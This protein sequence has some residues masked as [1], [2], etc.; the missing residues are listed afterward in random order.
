MPR[1]RRERGEGAVYYSKTRRRWIGQLDA[2]TDANGARVRPLVVG[3]TRDEART[4]LAELREARDKGIDIRSRHV[5]FDEVADLWLSRDV[6]GHVSEETLSNYTSLLHGRISR[7]IGGTPVTQLRATDVEKM[8]LE[9][10]E[11]G[12]SARYMRLARNL[13]ER[14]LDYAVRRDVVDRNVAAKVRAPAGPTAERYGLTVKQARR[15][16][17]V[18]AEDRLGNLVT[19]SL[20]LG[21]RPGEAA[22][23]TW[24]QVKLKGKR[25]TITVAASLRRTPMGALVLVPPKTRTSRRTL[26]V[27]P[28]VVAALKAQRAQQKADRAAA[29]RGWQ[30]SLNLVFTTEVG[31]PLDPSNVRRTYARLAQAAGLE[32][33]HPHMLRHAAASLLSAA[34]VPIEDISDTLGHRSVA[35]TAEVYRHP[36][37]PVRSG[38]MAAMDLL[39]PSGQP[40]PER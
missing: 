28:P 40:K 24:D 9:L 30:N 38:H 26:E 5:T 27:P 11:L 33:L 19:I 18:A 16:L 23:L 2:G 39:V 4:R 15:L 10:Q 20:L 1:Q 22:G 7:A 21:L 25:P 36:I 6:A 3:R 31:T 13:T 8:L 14:V 29:A 32:H 37:A 34:G 35:I 17:K 12:R